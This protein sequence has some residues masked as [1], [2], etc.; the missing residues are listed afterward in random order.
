MSASDSELQHLI[1]AAQ[2]QRATAQELD[3]LAVLL[4]SD[5]QVL[6]EY[7]RQMRME[8]LLT[9]AAGS[10]LRKA[11]PRGVVDEGVVWPRI[12]WQAL[13]ACLALCGLSLVWAWTAP[14]V[15]E[16]ETLALKIAA[17]PFEP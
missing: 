15:D 11:A 4:R 7:V 1:R 5:P 17:A 8:A 10:A 12:G 14:T 3:R 6:A 16:D 13:A 2:E 9:Y